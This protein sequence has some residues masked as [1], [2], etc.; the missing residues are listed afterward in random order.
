MGSTCG[1]QVAVRRKRALLLGTGAALGTA[2]VAALGAA[3]GTALVAA[4]VA[5]PSRG[6][7]GQ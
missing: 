7:S 5:F 1:A 2:L 3:L 4:L 6:R